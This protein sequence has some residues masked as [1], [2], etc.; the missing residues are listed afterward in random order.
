MSDLLQDLRF[1][2]RTL[3]KQPA[4]GLAVLGMLALGIGANAA[5]FGIFNGFF[6]RPLP[7]PDPDRLVQF[8]ERAPR[9]NL[10]Y[11]G[12]PYPDFH[13]WREGNETFEGMAV[14]GRESFSVSGEGSA[15]RIGGASVTHDMA[16]VLG[17][18]PILGRDFQ[19][20]DDRPGAPDI[21][22]IT[23]GLWTE[24]FGGEQGILGQTVR[25]NA[26]PHTIVGVLPNEASFVLG[27][28]L[29]TPLRAELDETS[30]NYYLWGVGRL[31]P[32]VRMEMAQ[33][34][35]D[36]IHA[37]LKE[38]GPASDDTFPVLDSILDRALGDA[39]GPLAALMGSVGLL[40]LIAC[41]NIAG[42]M[43]ARALA[44]EKEVGIR[45]AMGAS[46]GRIVRQL[47]TESLTL[48]T[49]GGIIGSL[50]GLWGSSAL[51]ALSPDELPSWISFRP[52]YRFLLFVTGI[53]GLT[54]VLSGLVPALRAARDRGYGISLDAATRST[55]TPGKKR[56]LKSLV[57]FE[58]ALSVV[59]LVVA[60]LGVRDIQAVMEV[61]PGFETEG[62]LTFSLSLPSVKYEG[63]EPRLAFWD[64][65]LA[66]IRALPGVEVAGATT[67]TPLG[68]HWGQ[69]FR[70]EGA[71]ELGP[72]DV[73]PVTLNRVITPGYMEAM[74]IELLAGRFFR[75][76]DGADVG[77]MAVI[78]NETWARNN[79][80]DGDPLGKR[81]QASWEG[82]PFMTVVGVTRDTKHYGLDEEMRQ[83]IFQPLSQEPVSYA[84]IVIRTPLDPLSLVPQIRQ[85][86]ADVD[87]DVP[88]VMPRTM[89]QIMD[90]SLWGR[91]ITAWLFG[92]FAILALIL[93]VGGIY[94]VLSYTVTQRQLEIGIRMA[95]G[96][97]DRQV[98]GEVV[99]QGMVLVGLGAALGLAGGYGMA[100][101]VSSIF[102][103][104]GTGTLA[105]YGSVGAVLLAVGVLANL[106]PARKAARVSPIGALR[107]GE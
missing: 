18:H 13:F 56:G 107:A 85:L 2:M 55:G 7:F 45:V 82:A 54:A 90:Q 91:R 61:E 33:A 14:A 40:L 88:V 39:R 94:G 62:I 20:E 72:D 44:R 28:R 80:P 95:L 24:R 42:L 4:F 3:V 46:R 93:A 73:A 47:L 71:P 30:G 5:I 87:P 23:E 53:V 49:I 22:L 19:P 25:L 77:D 101:A 43:L 84:T 41:A 89:Q 9:W 10:D 38:D 29:W 103:G 81:I 70:P 86:T 102:F 92:G 59:L 100:R 35:L 26:R 63:D 8:D 98:L 68:G 37:N 15:E 76:S 27:A 6:L 36:R 105:L 50:V 51:V 31:R 65:Y 96:A 66:R 16:E 106:L 1:S 75:D 79:F 58:V 21:V 11:V 78:L 17:I 69:F 97:Q 34:D 99:R 64:D 57:V 104:V 32:G 48:A 83:G 74:G 12:M 52:D 67:A 60:G